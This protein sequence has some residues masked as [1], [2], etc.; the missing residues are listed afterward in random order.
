MLFPGSVFYVKNHFHISSVYQRHIVY[1]Y[2]HLPEMRVALVLQS[3]V[4]S[5]YVRWQP[6]PSCKVMDPK[7]NLTWEQCSPCNSSQDSMLCLFLQ[8]CKALEES[9]FPPALRC[10]LNCLRVHKCIGKVGRVII[11]EDMFPFEPSTSCTRFYCVYILIC[12]HCF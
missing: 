7:R 2:L 3:I 10:H 6:I 5:A 8:T 12:S 9:L 4:G 1:N 11:T